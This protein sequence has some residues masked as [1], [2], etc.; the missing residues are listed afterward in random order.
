ML[1]CVIDVIADDA[2]ALVF[3]HPGLADIG[4]PREAIL[5]RVVQQVTRAKL[6]IQ[7]LAFLA[8]GP[9]AGQ[10]SPIGHDAQGLLAHFA[11]WSRGDGCIKLFQGTLNLDLGSLGFGLRQAC[12]KVEMA[13]V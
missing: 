3:L 12:R 8:I 6:G 2:G 1:A 7:G 10:E 5:D 4:Q 11:P 13:I 9:A